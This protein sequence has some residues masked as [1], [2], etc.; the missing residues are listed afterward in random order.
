MYVVYK[1]SLKEFK[2]S[3]LVIYS[4]WFLIKNIPIKTYSSKR[5]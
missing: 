2:E 3:Y 1:D 5:T 4:N